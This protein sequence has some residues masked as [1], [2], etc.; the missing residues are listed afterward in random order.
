MNE[1]PDN[2]PWPTP[3][4]AELA[5]WAADADPLTGACPRVP[6][7]L[8]YLLKH[9]GHRRQERGAVAR[10]FALRAHAEPEWLFRTARDRGPEVEDLS[11]PPVCFGDIRFPPPDTTW[12]EW[13][14]VL[15]RVRDVADWPDARAV[16]ESCRVRPGAPPEPRA[17][18]PAPERK[19]EGEGVL[20]LKL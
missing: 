8:D 16:I 7:A 17:P 2:T 9:E 1:A 3:I 15:R 14:V 20:L 18:E 4:A 13:A 19:P 10:L 12:R 5:A 11:P 6:E